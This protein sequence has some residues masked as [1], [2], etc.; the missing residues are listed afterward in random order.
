MESLCMCGSADFL[1]RYNFEMAPCD[2]SDL[3]HYVQL[4][5]VILTLAWLKHILCGQTPRDERLCFPHIWLLPTI[6]LPPNKT[7]YVLISVFPSPPFPQPL[8]T[9]VLLPVSVDLPMLGW[10]AA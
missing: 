2:N 3:V 10:L 4:R 7:L 9:T 5:F 1:T 6:P 8:A